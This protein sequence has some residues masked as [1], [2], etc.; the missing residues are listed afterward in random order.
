MSKSQVAIKNG[1]DVSGLA[2]SFSKKLYKRCESISDATIDGFLKILQFRENMDATLM[3]EKASMI[4]GIKAVDMVI[5]HINSSDTP[6]AKRLL[7][8]VFIVAE[9][10][11]ELINNKIDVKKDIINREGG[12]V[13]KSNIRDGSQS[14]ED[15]KLKI[16]MKNMGL[17]IVPSLV[18]FIAISGSIAAG[19]VQVED[20]IDIFV[21]VRNHTMW[22][23]RLIVYIRALLRPSWRSV[24]RFRGGND[25]DKFC[26]NFIVEESGLPLE[27]SIFN[28]H[29]LMFLRPLCGGTYYKILLEKHAWLKDFGWH[30]WNDKL[31]KLASKKFSCYRKVRQKRLKQLSSFTQVCFLGLNKL[32]FLIQIGYMLFGRNF[33][34]FKT[35]WREAK[36]HRIAI[37][38]IEPKENDVE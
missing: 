27:K 35:V 22:L 2:N 23:Y 16:V 20:D 1:T 31:E 8:Q 30:G 5:K 33:Y 6:A 15:R 14:V 18:K 17:L 3:E 25:K 38:K 9:P 28:F 36:L 12:I 7:R 21:V 34:G 10:H 24:L 11:N 13:K 26:L 37:F 29:E 4:F 19:T 32:A